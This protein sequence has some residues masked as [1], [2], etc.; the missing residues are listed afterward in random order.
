M[1]VPSFIYK[2][3]LDKIDGVKSSKMIEVNEENLPR[4]NYSPQNIVNN[5]SG[6]RNNFDNPNENNENTLP[7]VASIGVQTD[8]VSV[9]N[10]SSQTEP[11]QST[12]VQTND[13]RNDNAHLDANK[14]TDA[15]SIEVHR[16]CGC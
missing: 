5:G 4:E 6:S 15:K 1:M 13:I 11:Y 2:R 12:I 9:G 10:S 14:S 7:D 8:S 3:I 16:S